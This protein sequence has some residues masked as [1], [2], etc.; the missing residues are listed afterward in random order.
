MSSY[1]VWNVFTLKKRLSMA[2]VCCLPL[3]SV[4]SSTVFVSHS[5]GVRSMGPEVQSGLGGILDGDTL[6]ISD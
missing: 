6:F 4:P 3:C 1:S 2:L 5:V